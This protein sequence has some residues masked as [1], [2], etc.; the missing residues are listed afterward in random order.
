MTG[1]RPALGGTALDHTLACPGGVA[2][3][4][5][6]VPPGSAV[7]LDGRRLGPGTHTVRVPLRPG[8][9]FTLRFSGR[10][11]RTHSVRCLPADFPAWTTT[12]TA[13]PQVQ[14][15]VLSQFFPISGAYAIIA[16]AHGT[17]VWWYRETRGR[18]M[19]AKV[20]PD[21]T[22]AWS[23][24]PLV[25]FGFG[26]HAHRT[27]GGR[28]LGDIRTAGIIADP[29]ETLQLPGDRYLITVYRP[30]DHVDLR[31]IGG[32]ADARALEG[33]IHEVTASGRLLWSW[34]TRSHIT[35]SERSALSSRPTLLDGHTVYDLDHLNSIELDGP[36]HIVVSARHLNALYR[37]RRS[38]GTIDW[39]LGGA[40]TARSLRVVGDRL[41][42]APL[43]SAHDARVLADG[44]VTVHDN[45]TMLGRPPRAVR[46]R[47]DRARR[48][49]TLIED[50]QDSRAPRSIAGGSAR[51][52]RGGH[53]V[54]SWGASPLIT[55]LT[56]DG[57]PVLTLT[58][59]GGTS[60]RAQ[61]LEPGFLSAAELRAGMDRMHPRR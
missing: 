8:Q 33:E 1:I 47:I 3:V 48:T 23:A 51:R 12:R 57:S 5:A 56:P 17:P 27:L 32:P 49:A 26:P 19:D 43:D 2:T 16:D 30:R 35:M 42:A 45:G 60:Y 59:A 39:K 53:W 14:W 55:E 44:T 29:H 18:V 15:L 9:R 13:K 10:R 6:T 34:R 24:S 54:M 37:I 25:A 11:E 4:T 46:Y 20:L 40:P 36:D 38:T 31:A 58:L 52:L 28:Q 50:V 61:P 21:R 7:R 22:V 41:G